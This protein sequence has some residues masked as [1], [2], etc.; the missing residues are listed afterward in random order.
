MRAEQHRGTE[1]K[2]RDC[3]GVE[4]S[5]QNEIVSGQQRARVMLRAVAQAMPS[6]ERLGFAQAVGRALVKSWWSAAC[7]RSSASLGLRRAQKINSEGHLETPIAGIAE[8]MGELA[9]HLEPEIAAY[10]IGLTYTYLLPPSYRSS[11][12]IYYTPPVLT[13][14][15]IQLAAQS[16]VDWATGRVLDPACG[17]GAFLA[18]IAKLNEGIGF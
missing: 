9:A 1:F 2:Q 18:P 14:R 12:G 8:S 11:H 4:S 15:L 13:D 16:G 10:Q 6:E 17:G 7:D 5:D 3:I